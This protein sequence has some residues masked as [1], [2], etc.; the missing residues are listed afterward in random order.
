MTSYQ[1][2]DGV[3]L[4]MFPTLMY[5]GVL[6]LDHDLV[7][8]SVRKYVAIA[9]ER[10]G[11]NSGMNYTTYFDQDLRDDM[12]KLDWF[13]DF[14]N[15]MK[16]TYISFIKHAY[17]QE[18]SYLERNDI[19][20]FC[21]ANRYTKDHQHEM[22]N[23]VNSYISGTYYVKSGPECQPI[24]FLSPSFYS[25]FGLQTNAVP[26]DDDDPEQLNIGSGL[27]DSE[28]HFWPSTGKFLLWPSFMQHSVPPNDTGN[29]ADDYERITIS[30]NFDHARP[31]FD[32]KT[33]DNM[34][35][36]FLGETNGR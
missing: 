15:K 21:W 11:G 25:D 34:K 23:H 10:H 18:V 26:K 32:R 19:H 2:Q 29:I 5:K 20:F 16:D 22:H 28:V 3:I 31:L 35:Y 14:S 33:G 24:K 8:E 1:P 7:A 9:K 13:K 27:H 12:S 6:D 36:N 17:G 30:F 4:P